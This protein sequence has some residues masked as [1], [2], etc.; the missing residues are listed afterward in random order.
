[1]PMRSRLRLA[2]AHI[3]ADPEGEAT[4]HPLLGD[5][6]LAGDELADPVGEVPRRTP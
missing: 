3:P 2:R 5:P 6:G 4:E 1:M